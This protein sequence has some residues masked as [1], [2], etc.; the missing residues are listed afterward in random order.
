[1]QLR[2]HVLV[3]DDLD[4]NREALSR[5]LR[6]LGLTV[7]DAPDGNKALELAATGRFDVVLLDVM[8]P[9]MDGITVLTHLKA[10]EKT[11]DIP[12][13]MLSAHTEK[14]RIRQC[15]NLGADDYL[16][17]PIDMEALIARLASCLRKKVL[18]DQEKEYRRRLEMTN[19]E[20]RRLNLQKS[21]FLA[22]AAHDLKSP[23]TAVRLLAEQLSLVDEID[24]DRLRISGQRIQGSVER[25]L[26]TL[27]ALLDS[28]ASDSG[29]LK[30]SKRQSD[31]SLIVAKSLDANRV[32]AESKGIALAGPA[33]DGPAFYCQMD[34]LR[35]AEAVDN[36]I[37]NAIKFSPPGTKVEV[38]LS[39]EEGFPPMVSMKVK[40]QGPG[41]T[42]ED[43]GLVF[44][45]YQRLSAQPTGNETSTGLGLSI[46]KQMVEL[47]G[48]RV[49][50]DSQAN[51]GA[52]F[53]LEIPL[54]EPIPQAE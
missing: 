23:L 26:A 53:S 41:L 3:V 40:D 16:T 37:N 35:I 45:A 8:M 43:K 34:E 52:V 9:E 11:R 14:E 50:V 4:L 39:R 32:Y 27:Q 42:D 24:L 28:V 21:H 36:L 25:I 15:I 19:L 38:S 13:V 5:M 49:A 30:L 1:M 51:R 47:H 17:K 48:G 44:G 33:S 22:V 31:M 20:L 29:H 12:V 54:V 6:K 10:D 7:E 18:Q 46:V 2:G